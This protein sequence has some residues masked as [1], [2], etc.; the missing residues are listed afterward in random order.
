MSQ[1]CPKSVYNLVRKMAHKHIK[2]QITI[3]DIFQD[4]VSN[5]HDRRHLVISYANYL[6][7]KHLVQTLAEG[8]VPF[9]DLLPAFDRESFSFCVWGSTY[10]WFPPPIPTAQAGGSLTVDTGIAQ[11]SVCSCLSLLFFLCAC[12][13]ILWEF[14]PRDQT[15]ATAATQDTAV[16]IPDLS[17]AVSPGNSLFPFF[18]SVHSVEDLMWFHAFKSHP[19]LDG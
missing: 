2:S 15:H 1:S 9:Q 18:V 11:G 17:Q 3:K 14:Q 7:G 4:D 19:Y 8:C 12:T 16:T 13:H 10:T 5:D 6:C